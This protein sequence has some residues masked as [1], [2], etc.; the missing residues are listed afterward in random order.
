MKKGNKEKKREWRRECKDIKGEKTVK[1]VRRN[2]GKVWEEEKKKKTAIKGRK[3]SQIQ[4]QMLGE[5][6]DKR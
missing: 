6:K 4:T 5:G 3:K 1:E 2:L